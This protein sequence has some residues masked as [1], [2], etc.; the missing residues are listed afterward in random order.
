MDDMDE[1]TL[2]TR[3]IF[4][5]AMDLPNYDRTPS[6]DLRRILN[7]DGFLGPLL[8]KRM[9]YSVELDLYLRSMDE[10]HLYCGLTCLVKIRL[11]RSGKVWVCSHKTYSEQEC[12]RQLFRSQFSKQVDNYYMRG[13]WS[14]DEMG[15]IEALSVFLEEI[16]VSD[17]H[18]KEG[19]IHTRWAQVCKPWTVFDKEVRLAY[20]SGVKRQLF[21][22]EKV[23]PPVEKARNQLRAFTRSQRS[24]CAQPPQPKGSLKL[25]A[26]G[27][28]LQGNIVLLEIKDGSRSNSDVYYSPFQLLQNVWEWHLVFRFARPSVQELLNARVELGLTS[29]NVPRISGRIRTAIAFGNTE[30]SGRTRDLYFEVLAIVNTFLP[31]GISPMETWALANGLPVRLD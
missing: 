1:R 31:Q 6:K 25:D 12:A 30:P 10:V 7:P 27:F 15:F 4:V 13:E 8:N 18:R 2:S 3:T 21:M 20:P 28:D 11:S 19:A 29:R 17:R 24:R 9:R 26:L 5:T 22:S 14:V 23:M 16:E